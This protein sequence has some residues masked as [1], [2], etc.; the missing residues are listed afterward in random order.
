ME[1]Q[2]F[3]KYYDQMASGSAVKL[4]AASATVPAR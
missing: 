1:P 4:A 3:S 2:R